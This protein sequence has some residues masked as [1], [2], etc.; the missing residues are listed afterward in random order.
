MEL[1]IFCKTG[2]LQVENGVI[3]VASLIKQNRWEVPCDQITGLTAQPGGPGALTVTIYTTQGT[4]VV[5][6]V[7]ERNFS[8]LQVLFPQALSIGKEWYCDPARQTYI[9]TYTDE[10]QMQQEMEAA[11]QYGWVPQAVGGT[12][13]HINVGRTAAKVALLGPISLVTGASRSKD[14]IT[15]TFVRTP[16]WLAQHQ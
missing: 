5:E 13:G 3:R 10:K 2:K 14:K 7:A 1:N 6:T 9:T 8:K 4:H 16:E 11:S 12:A 15:I